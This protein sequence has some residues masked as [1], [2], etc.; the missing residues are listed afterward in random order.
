MMDDLLI[1]IDMDP[2][3]GYPVMIQQDL[4]AVQDMKGV[5]ALVILYFAGI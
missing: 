4:A 1:Y 2:L 5:V 3:V